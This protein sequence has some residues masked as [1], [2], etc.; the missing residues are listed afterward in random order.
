MVLVCWWSV[1][2][3]VREAEAARCTS[4][5]RGKNEEDDAL[6][7]AKESHKLAHFEHEDVGFKH[8]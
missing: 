7:L 6:L 1:R 8:V 4:D 2:P 3:D 5:A